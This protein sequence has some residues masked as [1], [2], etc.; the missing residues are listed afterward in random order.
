MV[1]IAIIILVA[2]TALP[3][4][5]SF[6]TAGADQQAFNVLSAQLAAARALAITRGTYAGVHVQMADNPEYA[7]K[8]YSAVVWDDPATPA[9]YTFDLAPGYQPQPLPGTMAFGQI[10]DTYVNEGNYDGNNL[11]DPSDETDANTWPGTF[12]GF[13]TFT[14]LFNPAGEVVTNG[15]G[16]GSINFRIAA[17]SLFAAMNADA[18]DFTGAQ[19]WRSPGSH[20]GT[21][22]VTLFDSKVVSALKDSDG[23]KRADYLNESGQFLAL[24]LYTGQFFHRE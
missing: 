23:T 15:P 7:G 14:I 24:N 16:G 12:Y 20:S 4:L 22:A 1:V 2:G 9:D 18:D 11:R 6:F 10:S 21:L 19:L 17:D 8:C 5:T 13:T 3:T